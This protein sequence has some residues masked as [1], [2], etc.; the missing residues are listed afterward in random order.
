[1]GEYPFAIARAMQGLIERNRFDKPLPGAIFVGPLPLS[2]FIAI[3]AAGEEMQETGAGAVEAEILGIAFAGIVVK[4]PPHIIGIIPFRA[5]LAVGESEIPAV[6]PN[7]TKVFLAQL[8]SADRFSLA[9]ATSIP[10]QSISVSAWTR[11]G[12]C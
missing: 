3:E 7:E 11:S 8:A 9:H 12:S 10:L 2:V 1:D 4:L 5:N 6:L